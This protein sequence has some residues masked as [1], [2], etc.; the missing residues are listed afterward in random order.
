M[1]TDNEEKTATIICLRRG[2]KNGKQFENETIFENEVSATEKSKMTTVALILG[3]VSLIWIPGTCFGLAGLIVSIICL[4]KKK[5]PKGKA[6]AGLI[7]SI[8]GPI[9]GIIAAVVIALATG[10]GASLLGTLGLS[11]LIGANIN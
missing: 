11:S 3:I 6:I 7:L 1:R 2:E 9:L 4:A 10:L 8:V 5:M